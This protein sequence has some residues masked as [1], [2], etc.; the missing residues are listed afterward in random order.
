MPVVAV[1]AA[2]A[3][4][5]P[6]LEQGA[7]KS[8]RTFF[9]RRD[10]AV[11][12]IGHGSSSQAPVPPE[13]AAAASDNERLDVFIS[14]DWGEDSKNHKRVSKINA[15]LKER[16]ITTWFDEEQMHGNIVDQMV[17]GIDASKLVIVIITKRYVEKVTSNNERDNCRLEFYYASRVKTASRMVPVVMEREMRN[18]LSWQ[19]AVGMI[20][21]GNL[22]VDVSSK[23]DKIPDQEIDQLERLIRDRLGEREEQRLRADTAGNAAPTAGD[24]VPAE[25]ATVRSTA[26][27]FLWK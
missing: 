14:H 12:A 11:P 1:G 22:Y 15:R 3:C 5:Q 19:G 13:V 10:N 21:G 17:Q 18:T 26:G 2:A 20:L 27:W 24:V 25:P 9:A 8:K 7:A 6:G 4:A 16:G 23:P